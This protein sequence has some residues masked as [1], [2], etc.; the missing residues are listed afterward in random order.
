MAA[1]IGFGV[2]MGIAPVWGFQT[3]L[4][5]TLSVF[6]RLNKVLSFAFSNISLP[7]FIPLI[8]YVSLIAGGAVL[9]SSTTKGL[10]KLD[11]IS[12]DTIQQHLLQYLVG[13]LLLATI[14]GLLAGFGSYVLIRMKQHKS[15]SAE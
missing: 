1:S 14:M 5:I 4:V 9:P 8:I 13:S 6:L 3:A 7:P 12:F 2:F 15:V 10:L 11:S